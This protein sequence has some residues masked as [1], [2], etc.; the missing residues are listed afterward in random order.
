MQ[1]LKKKFSI[2]PP[3]IR[4]ALEG[5]DHWGI[6]TE[7]RMRKDLP[8]SVTT[9]DKNIFLNKF[10]K[11]SDHKNALIATERELL[12]TV[13]AFCSGNLYRYFDTLKDGFLI[14][15]KGFRLGVCPAE[16]SFS[17]HLPES[18]EGI[19]LRIPREKKDAADGFL[20]AFQSNPL[21]S[22]LI[23]SPP[24][25]GKTTLLRALAVVLS[26]GFH[27]KAYR[28]AVI[29]ERREL[30]PARFSSAA[31]MCDILSG[32]NKEKGFEIANRI[33]SPEI[34][35]CDEIASEK[36]ADAVLGG[37]GTGCL[38]FASAHGG[39]IEEAVNRPFLKKLMMAK[40]FHHLVLMQR[41]KGP[42]FSVA[43][44]WKDLV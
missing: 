14:D 6:A 15:E 20:K 28:V 11:E 23:I 10:G 21:A 8:L 4:C 19:C 5:F 44:S 2:F 37:A 9:F 26:V 36:D 29:D 3:R 41:N 32:Y 30:F 42:L 7:I 39:S 13:C 43:L 35:I 12:E 27:G 34:I 24:G 22:T 40:V 1:E 18:F 38:I 33:L 16:N 25:V 17:T 31:G